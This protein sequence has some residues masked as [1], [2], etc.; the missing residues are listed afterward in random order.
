M[1]LDLV[2][3]RK[4]IEKELC[5]LLAGPG[6]EGAA[7][8]LP[9]Y[10]MMRYHMGWLDA[11]LNPVEADGGKRLRPIL[12]L[13]AC[14]AVG[15]H[16]HMALP[17]AASIE[18]IHNFSLI[19]DDI[20]DHSETRRHRRT[21]WALWGVPQAINTGDTM[22]TLARLALHRLSDRGCS[23]TTLLHVVRQLDQACLELC[24]G[25][26]L[27]LWFETQE[28]VSL[29]AYEQMIHGKTAALLSAS[30]AVGAIL[31]GAE[32]RVVNRYAAFGREL[33]L[34]FQIVDDIL[35][36]WGDPA[37]TGKSAASDI[38]TKKKTLPVLYAFH[39]EAERGYDD[40]ARIYTQ[41]SLSPDDIPSILALLGRCGAHEYTREQAR[42]HYRR[43]EN[44]LRAIGIDHPAQDALRELGHSLVE[45]TF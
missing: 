37:V 33:G 39:W 19:H 13:L 8:I 11:D 12:C 4:A 20:E 40:L 29:E 22:W 17:A 27:D 7:P 23:P 26:Y 6:Q 5:D 35:G 36:I 45:R 41:P 32:Q 21:V 1:T 34:T 42:T 14:E 3:Y 25:Q 2:P 18:L 31:G 16:W 44:H 43:A 9:L 10:A 28:S 24:T 15:G 30:L 38:L